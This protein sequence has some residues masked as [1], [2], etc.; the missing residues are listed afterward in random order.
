MSKMRHPLD[1]SR[2][3]GYY[4][5]EYNFWLNYRDTSTQNSP[6]N[7]I[8]EPQEVHGSEIIGHSLFRSGAK[9]GLP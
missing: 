9:C 5:G 4:L 6:N 7:R 1:Y 8:L 3:N 2:C